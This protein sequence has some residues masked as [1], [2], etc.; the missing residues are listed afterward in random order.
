MIT[1]SLARVSVDPHASSSGP[2]IGDTLLQGP[3]NAQ[4][5]RILVA[6]CLR[7]SRE[8]LITRSEHRLTPEES[9]LLA[10][11]FARRSVGEPIAYITGVR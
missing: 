11:V 6:H 4:E 8:Q 9:R 10:A 3:F 2:T 7:L 5:N 1:S